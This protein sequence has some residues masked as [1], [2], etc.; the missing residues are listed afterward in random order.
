MT[1]IGKLWLVR[2]TFLFQQ[3]VW[4]EHWRELERIAENRGYPRRIRVDNG[5]E[6]MSVK[7]E[8]W[9]VAHKVELMFIR[10]GKPTENA[11]IERFNRTY[12]HEILGM[13]VFYN[14][15]EVRNLTGEWINE[16]NHH[17]PHEALGNLP[18]A[19]YLSNQKP[20]LQK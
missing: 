2:S 6:F 20:I 7:L 9:C 8:A 16:Y 3:R 5:P 11:Y 10:P 18:P 14:L 15:R 12:R 1:L 19:K 17:R 4:S 13:W